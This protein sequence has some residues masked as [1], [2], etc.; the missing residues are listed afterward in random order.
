MT[1]RQGY[2]AFCTIGF[3][4]AMYG[5]GKIATWGIGLW[6]WWFV[7]AWIAGM[8]LIGFLMDHFEKRAH[9][10]GHSELEGL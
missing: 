3:V 4:F 1:R 2:I 10:R 5:I 9:R 7:G 8:L 6:S